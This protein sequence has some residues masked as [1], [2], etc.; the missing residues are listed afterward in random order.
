MKQNRSSSQTFFATAVLSSSFL[1]KAIFNGP[2]A[3]TCSAG[4]CMR[5]PFV[6]IG[7]LVAVVK[8]A[9]GSCRYSSVYCT[10]GS[11]SVV[12]M[13]ASRFA[14]F[15]P[16]YQRKINDVIGRIDQQRIV[17]PFLAGC[18]IGERDL[19]CPGFRY[20]G[21]APSDVHLLQQPVPRG[22]GCFPRPFLCRP[23]HPYV[24]LRICFERLLQAAAVM[25]FGPFQIEFFCLQVYIA[26]LLLNRIRP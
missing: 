24:L 2:S 17:F 1:E 10:P 12:G 25:N 3:A 15:I 14:F 20:F 6:S 18:R 26:A 4:D 5:R 23:L 13:V 21:L 7:G 22:L 8:G 16:G 9:I 11:H 19:Q